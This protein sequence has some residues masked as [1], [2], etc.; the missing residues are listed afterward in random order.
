M[1]QNSI[2]SPPGYSIRV[3]WYYIVLLI[4]ISLMELSFEACEQHQWS[5]KVTLQQA[6]TAPFFSALP[7]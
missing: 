6:S 5:G 3:E 7:L 1:H 2:I 4:R